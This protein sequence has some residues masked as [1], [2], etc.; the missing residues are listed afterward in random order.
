MDILFSFFKVVDGGSST[1]LLN[2]ESNI[3]KEKE[4]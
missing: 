3:K 4:S 2:K 1:M